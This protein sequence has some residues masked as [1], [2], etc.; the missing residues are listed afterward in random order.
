MIARPSA[1]LTRDRLAIPVGNYEGEGVTTG[2]GLCHG[3]HVSFISPQDHARNRLLHALYAPRKR[4]SSTPDAC[5]DGGM[6]DAGY[7]LPRI[8]LIRSS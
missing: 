5:V 2:A 7:E 6:R 1:V 4:V 8:R 3:A